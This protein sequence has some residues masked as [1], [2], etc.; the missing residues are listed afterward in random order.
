MTEDE[1]MLEEFVRVGAA[2]E[3][4]LVEE[5]PLTAAQQALDDLRAGRVIGRV[6]LRP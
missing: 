5:R 3:L 4:A 2:L 6:A 1:R